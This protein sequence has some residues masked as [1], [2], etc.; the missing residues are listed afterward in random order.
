MAC[1][2][3]F[4]ITTTPV[5]PA[6][7]A[8][9]ARSWLPNNS[10][11]RDTCMLRY[12]NGARGAQRSGLATTVVTDQASCINNGMLLH[13]APNI[14]TSDASD[15]RVS[16]FGSACSVCNGTDGARGSSSSA[17]MTRN[18]LRRSNTSRHV[19]RRPSAIVAVVLCSLSCSNGWAWSRSQPSVCTPLHCRL[20]TCLP[21]HAL[22]LCCLASSPFLAQLLSVHRAFC[23]LGCSAFSAL[24][25]LSLL[26]F[27]R[28]RE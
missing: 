13:R 3:S 2:D 28:R 21:C 22:L 9:P 16:L 12:D 24:S 14:A 6:I 27:R 1:R 11:T 25:V 23:V 8:I 10:T 17:K 7:F 15:R 18:P 5:I 4:R 19:S 26:V 20:P